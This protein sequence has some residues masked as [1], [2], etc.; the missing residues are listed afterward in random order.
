MID[1]SDIFMFQ[2]LEEKTSRINSVFDTD[3]KTNV[4]KTEELNPQELKYAL[5]KNPKVIAQFEINEKTEVLNEQ[6][7]DLTNYIKKIEEYRR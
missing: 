4:L 7:S 6:I 1:S 3:G 5:I 2:K